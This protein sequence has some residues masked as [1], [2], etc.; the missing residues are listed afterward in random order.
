MVES[1]WNGREWERLE[2]TAYGRLIFNCHMWFLE[3]NIGKDL[4]VLDAGCK[5]GRFALAAAKKGSQMTLLDISRGQLEMTENRFAEQGYEGRYICASV[6]DMTMLDSGSYD[7]VFCYGP[8][9]NE[10]HGGVSRA[11]NEL[12]RVLKRSGTLVISA[13]SR[14]GVL[15]TCASELKMPMT[16]FW[17]DGQRWGIES[18][19]ESGD[20]TAA[21]PAGHYFTSE[22]LK[23]LLVQNGLSEI[24]TG[25]APCIFTGQRKNTE[26]IAADAG[27]WKTLLYTE[28]KM[29]TQPGLADSGEY[30]LMKGMKR[31]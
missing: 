26:E 7:T 16:Y 24:K 13:L 29:F 19:A 20:E 22:E 17:G 27:A 4:K 18:F 14:A 23:K 2:K 15:R 28:N 8:T 11:A 1:A 5:N 25:A 3:P 12:I 21:Y 30:I 31:Q 9:L 6:T 10:L